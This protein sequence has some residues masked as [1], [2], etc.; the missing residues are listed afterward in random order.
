MDAAGWV[1]MFASV[2][3]V[4]VFFGWTLYLVF[5]RKPDED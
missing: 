4:T 3:F 2:G 5:T 1:I